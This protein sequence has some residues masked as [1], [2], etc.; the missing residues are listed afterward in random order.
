M[1]RD[2]KAALAASIQ[3]EREATQ[4]RVPRFDK[5]EKAEAALSGGEN[6]APARAGKP[7]D[8]SASRRPTPVRETPAEKVIRDSFTMPSGDYRKITQLR[9]K[10]LK[11]G[12]NMT[13]SEI[14]RAGLHALEELPLESLRAVVQSVEK[15]KTGR[16]GRG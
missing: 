14:L 5:F 3:A 15:V 7:V 12:M 2:R 16:P 9:A 10:C 11:A 1:A 4:G 6:P 8:A 13:K